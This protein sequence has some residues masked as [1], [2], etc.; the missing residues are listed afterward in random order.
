MTLRL[1]ALFEDRVQTLL[2]FSDARKTRKQRQINKSREARTATGR[3][4]I[5]NENCR[6]TS[7][8]NDPERSMR[9]QSS[10]LRLVLRRSDDHAETF[11][12]SMDGE[13]A[14]G[15]SAVDSA[16][17]GK[18]S[19]KRTGIAINLRTGRARELSDENISDSDGAR[20]NSQSPPDDVVVKRRKAKRVTMPREFICARPTTRSERRS[21]ENG[22]KNIHLLI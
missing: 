17:Q 13:A 14:T 16:G 22:M 15:S 10:S 2:S 11:G 21:D 3:R 1:S 6:E 5:S 8:S 9:P 19:P 4:S 12:R 18:T 20:K 7:F